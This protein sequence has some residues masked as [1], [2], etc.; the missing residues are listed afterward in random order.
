MVGWGSAAGDLIGR[1]GRQR[2]GTGLAY[3]MY[4]LYKDTIAILE[5]KRW[6]MDDA[7]GIDSKTAAWYL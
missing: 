3:G 7:L 2:A 1:L 5:L 6:Q 4:K